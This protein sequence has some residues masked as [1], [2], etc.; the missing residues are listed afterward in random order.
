MADRRFLRAIGFA[1]L[2]TG[3]TTLAVFFAGLDA[4]G[5]ERARADAFTTLVFAEILKAFVFR[6]DRKTV[7]EVGLASN[8]KLLVVAVATGLLQVLAGFVPPFGNF[9]GMPETSLVRYAVLALV[10]AS[11][12]TVLE[13]LKLAGRW[14]PSGR[15]DRG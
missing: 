11:P 8:A 7:F 9:L 10:A 1:G 3:A 5:I 13:V 14:H 4:E 2:L 6:N 15:K 12:V